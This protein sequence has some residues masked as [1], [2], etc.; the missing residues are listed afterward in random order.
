MLLHVPNAPALAATGLAALAGLRVYLAGPMRGRPR[1]NFD[2]FEQAREWLRAQGADVTCPAEMDLALG[3]DPD[4]GLEEQGFDT[5]EALRRD[6]AAIAVCDGVVFLPG[7]SQSSGALA[8]YEMA[9][10]LAL[11]VFLY[12]PAPPVEALSGPAVLGPLDHAAVDRFLAE[13]GRSPAAFVRHVLR[14]TG[15]PAA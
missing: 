3:F 7:S 14:E 10:A 13:E 11:D 12:H 8:E 4:R 5:V 6:L 1:Y 15:I 9:R 2:A